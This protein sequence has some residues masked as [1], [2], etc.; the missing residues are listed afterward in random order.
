ML[1]GGGVALTVGGFVSVCPLCWLR[2]FWVGYWWSSPFCV[3]GGSLHMMGCEMLLRNVA[4][5]F[6]ILVNAR[7]LGVV[8][9]PWCSYV[10][11]MNRLCWMGL[12]VVVFDL[13]GI[14]GI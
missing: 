12:W 10:L 2:A 3:V 13:S 8:S 1:A 5:V 9:E 6:L 14:W 11:G 4:G 7:V